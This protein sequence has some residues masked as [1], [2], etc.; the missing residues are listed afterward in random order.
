MEHN[1]DILVLNIFAN[2]PLSIAAILGR[3][4]C[5][6]SPVPVPFVIFLLDQLFPFCLV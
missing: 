2:L 3:A 6:L 5:A 1:N 4:L